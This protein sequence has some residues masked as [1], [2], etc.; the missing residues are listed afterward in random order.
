MVPFLQGQWLDVLSCMS[1]IG[2]D[3]CR[4]MQLGGLVVEVFENM[5]GLYW[6]FFGWRFASRYR[7]FCRPLCCHSSSARSEV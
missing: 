4:T 3:G 5:P 1:I 2:E 7:C 6:G